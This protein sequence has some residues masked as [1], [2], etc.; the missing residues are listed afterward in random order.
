M[1]KTLTHI[2][3]A[4]LC[5]CFVVA[6]KPSESCLVQDNV[7]LKLLFTAD[8]ISVEGDSISLTKLDSLTLFGLGNDSIIL[9]NSKSVASVNLPL[10]TDTTVT[11]F[12]LQYSD[13]RD[14]FRVVHTNREQFVSLA[15]GCF[16]YHDIDTVIA[17]SNLVDSITIINQ[18]IENHV[19]DN[20]SFHLIVPSP[21]P[22]DTTTNP[23]IE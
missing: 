18:T 6:C 8:S 7:R 23:T 2:A 3:F 17:T 14:T 21:I 16:V 11:T 12:V 13:L 19:Q 10:R 4:V 1:R 20:V 5:A 9:N 15:C 22:V